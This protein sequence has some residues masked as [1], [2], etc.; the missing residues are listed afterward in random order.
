[1]TTIFLRL[2]TALHS[3]YL[4]QR[5]FSQQDPSIWKFM[6]IFK[7]ISNVMPYFFSMSKY[8]VQNLRVRLGDHNIKTDSEATHVEKRVKRVIRHKGFSSSTLVREHLSSSA[9]LYILSYSGMMLLFWPWKMRLATILTSNP[10]AWPKEARN[11]LETLWPSQDGGLCVRVDLSQHLW[12]RL[13]W[14]CGPT[15]SA[16]QAMVAQLQGES[17]ATCCVQVNQIEIPAAWVTKLSSAD[18]GYNNQFQKGEK[19]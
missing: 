5:N 12:W 17:P 10:S 15:R 9:C 16:R 14:K 8:D 3:E 4:I 18:R 1:M 2:P 6:I 11:M 19:G 7:S 13:M